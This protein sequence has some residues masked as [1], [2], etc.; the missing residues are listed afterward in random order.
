MVQKEQ[1]V[2][3]ARPPKGARIVERKDR[4][5]K[6][7]P[8]IWQDCSDWADDIRQLM[9]DILDNEVIRHFLASPPEYIVSDNMN[10]LEDIILQAKG[11]VVDVK[12]ML[13]KRLLENYGTLRA[14]HARCP[15]EI[16]SYYRDGL[17][18]LDYTTAEDFLREFFL[19]GAC[20]EITETEL[21]TAMEGCKSELRG[22]HV[23]FEAN[24]KLLVERCG[25]YLLYGS[26]YILAVAARLSP[27][28]GKDY[29][30]ALKGLGIPTV[31]ACDVPLRLISM[32]IILELAGNMLEVMFE[33]ILNQ[34]YYHPQVPFGFSIRKTL[35]PKF[36]N[37]HYHPKGVR[38][39]IR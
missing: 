26:E 23:Y 28:S 38:D 33:R 5:G 17:L 15:K 16:S 14:F 13:A 1:G 21:L 18:P 2:G 39:P 30:R 10:W 4:E 31:F 9:S 35:A 34:N 8:V 37:S 36:I 32:Q 7:R 3:L 11:S 25:H 24:E 27:N 6:Q 29:R 20:P 19:S 22:G 12:V